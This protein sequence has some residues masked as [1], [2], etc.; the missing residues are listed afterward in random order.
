[1]VLGWIQITS[2]TLVWCSSFK[3]SISHSVPGS[4]CNCVSKQPITDETRILR[5]YCLDKSLK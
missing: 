3:V 1:M 2:K 4:Y 5:M